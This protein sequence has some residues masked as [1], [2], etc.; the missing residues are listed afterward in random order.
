MRETTITK[1][2]DLDEKDAAFV[3]DYIAERGGNQGPQPQVGDFLEF[4]DGKDI[5]NYP[6]R[7]R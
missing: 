4:L 3:A 7:G 2:E 6:G 1:I 5:E